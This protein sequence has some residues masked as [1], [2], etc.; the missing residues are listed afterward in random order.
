MKRKILV[1]YTQ[2]TTCIK[3]N[4]DAAKNILC[5]VYGEKFRKEAYNAVNRVRI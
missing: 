5:S 1:I 4:A 2:D 3:E